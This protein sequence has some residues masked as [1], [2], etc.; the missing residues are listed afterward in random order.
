MSWH[1]L[2]EN[3]KHTDQFWALPHVSSCLLSHSK[4]PHVPPFHG[5]FCCPLVILEF[6]CCQ[7]TVLEFTA[8]EFTAATMNKIETNKH[9]LLLKCLLY[10][11]QLRSFALYSHVTKLRAQLRHPPFFI[12][13]I[14]KLK[15]WYCTHIHTDLSSLEFMKLKV[16]YIRNL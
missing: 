15:L 4:I 2:W 14:N 13:R 12:S 7:Q 10:S 5:S 3:T 9:D 6:L 11:A 1:W 16:Q 8:Q